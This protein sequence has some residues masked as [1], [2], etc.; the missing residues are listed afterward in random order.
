M[1]ELAVTAQFTKLNGQP[2][3]A[4]TLIDIDITLVSVHKDTKVVATV[5]AGLNPT[6]EITG[7]GMYLRAYTADLDTYW[8]FAKAEYTGGTAL[9][10]NYAYGQVGE[11]FEGAADTLLKRGMS[12]V[13]NTADLTS[14]AAL[15]LAAFESEVVG[16]TWTIRK[17]TGATFATKTVTTDATANPIT[18]V[19]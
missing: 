14:L 7:L 4:L 2:A 19:T 16:T 10:S 1:T 8:Y 6:A 3:T 12:N 15:V 18:G 9:D 17:T 13:E 5:W 11:D